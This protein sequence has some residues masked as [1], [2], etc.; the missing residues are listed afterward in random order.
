[1]RVGAV[2]ESWGT[3]RPDGVEDR[4]VDALGRVRARSSHVATASSSTRKNC[5]ACAIAS[6]NGF[7]HQP[8]EDLP[9]LVSAH[10]AQEQV[11]RELGTL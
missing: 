7:R 6:G 10:G 8:V 2:D 11:H 4:H 1:M 9:I 5:S 3:L